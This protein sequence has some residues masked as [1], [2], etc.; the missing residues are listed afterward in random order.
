ML[1]VSKVSNIAILHVLQIQFLDHRL[2]VLKTLSSN[3]VF[4]DTLLTMAMGI[5]LLIGLFRIISIWRSMPY[6]Y[7]LSLEWSLWPFLFPLMRIMIHSRVVFQ[8]PTCA[9]L[10]WVEIQITIVNLKPNSKFDGTCNMQ[11]G[12]NIPKV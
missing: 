1:L 9:F 7:F 8:K 12:K 4:G 2:C 5:K 6:I 11:I 10:L 3:I